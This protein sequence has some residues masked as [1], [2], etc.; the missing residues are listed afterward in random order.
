MSAP[1]GGTSGQ[2]ADL[3]VGL[4]QRVYCPDGGL[5]FPKW[6]FLQIDPYHYYVYTYST[7]LLYYNVSELLIISG[8]IFKQYKKPVVGS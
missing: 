5:G 8:R 6:G 2:C 4:G 1:H 3:L 7:T